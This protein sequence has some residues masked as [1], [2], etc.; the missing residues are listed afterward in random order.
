MFENYL[1]IAVRNI[2]KHKGYSFINVAGLAIGVAC[3]I[4]ILLFVRSE[5]S[6]DTFHENADRI[7]RIGLRFNVGSNQFD[8]AVGPVPAANAL[9]NDYPEVIAATRIY[10]RN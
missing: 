2:N 1:K 9:M 4:L 7:H 8:A 3:C 10:A 6:Y 5:L